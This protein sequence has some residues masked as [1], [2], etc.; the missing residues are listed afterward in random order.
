MSI[1]RRYRQA[2]IINL[3]SNELHHYLLPSLFEKA[4]TAI[5]FSCLGRYPDYGDYVNLMAHR[6]NVGPD[7]LLITPGTDS[8]IR[9][10]CETYNRQQKGKGKLLLSFPNYF[11]WERASQLYHLS[12]EKI[13]ISP[14]DNDFCPLINAARSTTQAL[15]ALTSPCGPIG[16]WVCDEQLS[17]LIEVAELND[18]LLVLDSCYQAFLGDVWQ[19]FSYAKGRVIVVQ[20][21]SK[22]HGFAGERIGFVVAESHIIQSLFESNIEHHVSALSLEIACYFLQKQPIFEQIW[23]EI[24][25]QREQASLVLSNA[26]F[27]II[28]SGGNFLTIALPSEHEA[29]KLSE[30]LLKTGYRIKH[31]TDYKKFSHMIRFA[32]G[33]TSFMQP[34]L[35]CLLRSIKELES[36][37][38]K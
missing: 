29:K 12:C 13:E 3:S 36:N 33:D 7:N 25:V 37:H 16:G 8:A 27:D 15:I 24:K 22:S 17:K 14:L 6:M 10:I 18:H 28:E 26:G 32:I 23:R 11:A 2:G 34:F 1:K 38:G 19:R 31:L 30:M 4:K 5:D 21:M 9:L 20:S 35:S